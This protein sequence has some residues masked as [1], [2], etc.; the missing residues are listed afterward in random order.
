[1]LRYEFLTGFFFPSIACQASLLT[2]SIVNPG[3]ADIAFWEALQQRSIP[4]WS[5]CTSTPPNDATA[6]TIVRIPFLFAIGQRSCTGFR[7]PAGVSQWTTVIALMSF[8][9]S[10]FSLSFSGWNASLLGE[11]R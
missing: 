4:H 8:S 6:S 2:D 5:G 1:M 9:T 11:V 10:S 3:G 7:I